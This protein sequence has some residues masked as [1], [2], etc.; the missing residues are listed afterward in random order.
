MS[1]TQDG[2]LT[3]FSSNNIPLLQ[4][5]RSGKMQK[6]PG[7]V[8]E[9]DHKTSSNLLGMKILSNG[10]SV[11]YLGIKFASDSITA[12]SSASLDTA[13]TSRK[14]QMVFES[15]SSRYAAHKTYLGI[16]S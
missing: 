8:L 3:L 1:R 5:D 10:A 6:Y 15:I 16:S 9:L 14:N 2:G 11:G 7:I 13:L 12:V 4:I